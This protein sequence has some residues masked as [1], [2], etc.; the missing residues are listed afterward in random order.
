MTHRRVLL[1][2]GL[3]LALLAACSQDQLFTPIPPAYTG[4]QLFARYVAMGNSITAGFQSGGIND[5]T[6]L[7]SYARLVANVMGTG[8]SFP[9]LV[10]PGC[11][12][13]FTNIFTN[14]RLGPGSTATTCYFRAMPI[15]PFLTNVAV[16]GAEV[17]DI[18]HNGPTPGTNSNALTQ[19]FLGGRTQ[20]QAMAAAHPTFVSVWIG[21]NDV[22]GSVLSPT[23][24]GDSTLITPVA[25]FQARYQEIVDSIKAANAQALLI[26]VA[27]VTEIPFVSQGAT[28]FAIK[29]GLV[30]GVPSFPPTFQVAPICAPSSL[31]GKGDSVFVPF[32]FGA[33]LIAAAAAGANDTLYCTELQTVQPAESKEIVTTVAAYNAFISSAATTNNWAY[34]DPAPI[35]DSLRAIPSQV[36]PFPTLGQPCSVSPFGAAFSCDGFHPST[37]THRL[38]A[39]KVVQAINAKYG[40]AIPAVP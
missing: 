20:V 38:I 23:N 18:L 19:L 24:A 8:Y 30:P 5:T 1:T 14:T 27:N 31:G 32:P 9:R 13:P 10:S 15:P 29:N 25:T 37:A 22:L 21:N 35:L 36:A 28:Y 7:Q 26:G 16:P 17:M 39:K 12:P 11:P 6:Q 2:A 3:S 4:G 33:A 40:S 34:L